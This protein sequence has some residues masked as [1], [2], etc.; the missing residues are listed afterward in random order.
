MY[1]LPDEY[2][3]EGLLKEIGNGLREYIKEAEETKLRRYTSYA[4][5]CI[6]MRLD[7]ALPDSV[8]LS[9]YDHEWIQPLDYE[10]VPFR[11]RKYHAHGHLF[12]DCPLNAKTSALDPSSTPT[13]DGFAKVPSCK[14][15][16][17]KPSTGKKPQLDSA[18][19]PSTS[20]SFEILSQASNEQNLNIKPISSP[21]AASSYPPPSGPPPESQTPKG[22]EAT[23]KDSQK[24]PAEKANDMEFDGNLDQPQSLDISI[25]EN[26]QVQHMY[27]E[28]ESIDMEGLEI[29]QLE[30]ACKKRDYDNI[31]ELQLNKLEVVISIW[32][33]SA[34]IF[35]K[36]GKKNGAPMNNR[37]RENPGGLR[38]VC[39][40]EKVLQTL[41]H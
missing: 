31:P 10:H 2:W 30:L 28:P 26:S 17:K 40:I 34:K 14:Q 35:Q 27:E 32:R 24:E 36:D 21:I 23:P 7:Q 15:V 33:S 22:V 18:S 12:K 8:S 5:I 25:A 41:Y 4:R 29:L 1:S 3:D 19:I 9:H 16:H 39:K 37:S 38:Q 20:N 13:Q 11:C 6:F